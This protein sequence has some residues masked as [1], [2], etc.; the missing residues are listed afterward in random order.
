MQLPQEIMSTFG[1]E[2]HTK[3]FPLERFVPFTRAVFLS[4]RYAAKIEVRSDMSEALPV[5]VVEDEELLLSFLKTALERG[6]VKVVGA[7]SGSE[8]L[9]LLENGEFAGV[10]S[11]LRIPGKIRGG[12]IFDWV[13]RIVRS[14]HQNSCSLRAT[15][16]TRTPLKPR[17]GPARS[18]SKNHSGSRY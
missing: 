11:D 3:T 13:R 18:L 1:Y 9:S 7:T 10:V 16:M 12:E 5:L 17:S 2:R 8:A 14:C 15:S 6:G 4:C